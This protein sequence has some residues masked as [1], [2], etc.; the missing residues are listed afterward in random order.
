MGIVIFNNISSKE[1]GVEVETFPTYNVPEKVYQTISVPG[2]NGDV[3]FDTKTF[4]G[5]Q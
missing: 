5:T 1:V 4:N 3:V 2:R